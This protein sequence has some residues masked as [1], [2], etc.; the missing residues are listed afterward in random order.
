VGKLQR[1]IRLLRFAQAICQTAGSDRFDYDYPDDELAELAQP[2][3]TEIRG[4]LVQVCSG[5]ARLAVRLHTV[6]HSQRR[7]EDGTI[8]NRPIWRVSDISPPSIWLSG[9]PENSA[10]SGATRAVLRVQSRFLAAMAGEDNIDPLWVCRVLQHLGGDSAKEYSPAV[11]RFAA[12]FDLKLPAT[13]REMTNG[14][15]LREE[16]KEGEWLPKAPTHKL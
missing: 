3:T 4:A 12:R 2:M 13:P 7:N 15:T 10:L 11:T 6:E 5:L 8:E 14:S 1:Q 9:Y 16:L